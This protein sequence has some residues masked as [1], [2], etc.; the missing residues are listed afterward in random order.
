MVT[1]APILFTRKLPGVISQKIAFASNIDLIKFII[2]QRMPAA[3]Y[4]KA[5]L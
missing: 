3:K 2:E 5:L 1:W 4:K